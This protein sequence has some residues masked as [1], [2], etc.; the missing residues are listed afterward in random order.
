MLS[1]KMLKAL[2][3]Q[4]KSSVEE[5]SKRKDLTGPSEL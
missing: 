5:Q 3:E 2:N 4:L 1:D